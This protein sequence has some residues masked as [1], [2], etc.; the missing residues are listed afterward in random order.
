MCTW[1]AFNINYHGVLQ[2]L[3]LKGLGFVR[4]QG[5]EANGSHNGIK[6]RLVLL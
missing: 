6:P 3:K 4:A 5:L 2:S 1:Y